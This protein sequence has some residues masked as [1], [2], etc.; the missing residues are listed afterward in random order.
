MIKILTSG[1]NEGFPESFSTLLKKYVKSEMSFAFV[2]SEFKS[3][4]RETDWYCQ[5]FLKMFS[6]CG[7]F[8]NKVQVIDSRMTKSQAQKVIV[9]SDVIWLAGG[10]T[11]TQYKYFV[12]YGLIQFLR[13]HKGVIIGMSAGSINMSKTAICTVAAKHAQQYIYEALGVVDFSV[14]PHFNKDDISDELLA[15][16]KDYPLYAICDDSAIFCTNGKIEYSGDVFLIK[17]GSVSS[18]KDV[19]W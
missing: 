13:K 16:S 17:D 1:F 4:H 19:K 2:A 3:A 11:P 12:E 9:D 14:E 6:E 8:F 10:D 7:I 15:I 5:Y 18:V